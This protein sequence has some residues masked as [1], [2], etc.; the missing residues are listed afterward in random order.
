MEA[1][2]H[3]V[4]TIYLRLT[5]ADVNV[6]SVSEKLQE[7]LDSQ[8]AVV[9]VD[10]KGKEIHESPGTQGLYNS[11]YTNMYFLS[12][13]MCALYTCMHTSI[14]LVPLNILMKL[15]VINDEKIIS[16]P[17]NKIMILASSSYNT[18]YI[19]IVNYKYV[20]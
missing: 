12:G 17:H 16:N 18:H 6:V 20:Q 9:L 2:L 10:S 13:R 14:V 1:N 11:L 5:D 7:Q 8:E 15:V 19:F 4:Q 3:P